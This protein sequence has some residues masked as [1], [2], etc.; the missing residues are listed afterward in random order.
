MNTVTK[1]WTRVVQR[2]LTNLNVLTVDGKDVGFVYKPLKSQN[3][4]NTWRVHL[5]LGNDTQFMGHTWNLPDAK[6]L[7]EAFCVGD[8]RGYNN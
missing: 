6:R 2:S 3:E 1:K 4:R 5:G 7:L 8:V